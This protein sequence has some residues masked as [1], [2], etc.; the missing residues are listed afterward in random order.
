MGCPPNKEKL[1]ATEPAVPK[2]WRDAVKV[3]S[4]WHPWLRASAYLFYCD[5]GSRLPFPH[6]LLRAITQCSQQSPL[7]QERN[8]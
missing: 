4:S 2:G 1:R 6:L 8:S 5:M 3:C 7:S